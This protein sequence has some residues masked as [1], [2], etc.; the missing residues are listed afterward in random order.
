ML[1]KCLFQGA[2]WSSYVPIQIYHFFLIPSQNWS[3]DTTFKKLFFIY[4]SCIYIFL[5]I[6]LL[7]VITDHYVLTCHLLISQHKQLWNT[8][9]FSESQDCCWYRDIQQFKHNT[10]LE[11]DAISIWEFPPG[12]NLQD[13]IWHLHFYIKNSQKKN[14]RNY[15]L[16]AGAVAY[17]IVLLPTTPTYHMYSTSCLV[18]YTSKPVYYYCAWERSRPWP[19]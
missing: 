15:F 11:R 9:Q 10:Y 14:R 2:F 18:G 5:L 19:T 12:N 7:T 13:L 6:W 8:S 16:G 1:W 3:L 17:E 4:F